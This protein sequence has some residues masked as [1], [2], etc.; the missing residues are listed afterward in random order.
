MERTLLPQYLESIECRLDRRTYRPFLDIR[1]R[2]LI[3]LAKLFGQS[4]RI[5][6]RV[7]S[8]KEI[9]FS[10]E[11]VFDTGPSGLHDQGGSDAA[12]RRHPAKVECFLDVLGVAVPCTKA[13]GLMGRVAQEKSQLRNVQSRRTAG[14]AGRDKKQ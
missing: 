9:I 3:A 6:M 12:A 4:G 14:G 5:G 8:V 11:D 1:S 13:G 10:R 2:N 7:V